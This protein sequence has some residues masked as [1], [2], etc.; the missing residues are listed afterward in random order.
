MAAYSD[1]E[2]EEILKRALSRERR[3]GISH[4]DLVE[5]AGEVGI[6]RADVEAAAAELA[7]EREQHSRKAEVKLELR[8]RFW[9]LSGNLVAANLMLVAVDYLTGPERWFYWVTL[10]SVAL[11]AQRALRTFAPRE[12]DMR[13]AERRLARRERRR[14]RY[15]AKF[16]RERERDDKQRRKRAEQEFER[17]VEQGVEALLRSA[18]DRL[19]RYNRD[20]VA[21][22][23]RVDPGTDLSGEDASPHAEHARADEQQARQQ[24]RR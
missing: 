1:A 21:Q 18:A 17:V 16:E 9:S 24:R 11:L 7:R 8:R 19:E 6:D 22:R 2:A 13:R 15:E 10:A 14:R 20:R 3:E 5:A 4:D 23:V 12:Q